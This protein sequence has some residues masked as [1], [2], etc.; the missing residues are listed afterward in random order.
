MWFDLIIIPH[1]NLNNPWPYSTTLLICPRAWISRIS[2][3]SNLGTCLDSFSWPVTSLKLNRQMDVW[4]QPAEGRVTLSLT[5]T[6]GDYSWCFDSRSTVAQEPRHLINCGGGDEPQFDYQEREINYS[7]SPHPRQLPLSECYGRRSNVVNLRIPPPEGSF[8][9]KNW[10]VKSFLQLQW[11]RLV[12][13]SALILS[14][15]PSDYVCVILFFLF[16]RIP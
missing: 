6:S 2:C 13:Q 11:R 4:P 1:V 5:S 14:L 3:E 7:S 9:L 16:L 12:L 8:R 10:V 15:P